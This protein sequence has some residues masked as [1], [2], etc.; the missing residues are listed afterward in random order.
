[1]DITRAA[2]DLIRGLDRAVLASAL[3]VSPPGSA[4]WP[5]ASLVLVAADHDLSPLLLISNL[6]EHTRA[7]AQDDRVS[8]L[9]DG[10]AGLAQPL[11]GPRL[12]VL[13]RAAP[14]TDARLIARYLGRHP[15]AALYASFADFQFYRMAIERAHLVG[16]FGKIYWIAAADLLSAPPPAALVEAEAEIVAHMNDD[17]ADALDLY[18]TRLLGQPG[19][20]WRMTGIDSEG[21]DLRREGLVRRVPFGHPVGTADEARKALVSLAFQARATK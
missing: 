20:G 8:L 6:A 13:G 18:A 10:T 15:D 5:Y 2:R 4:P 1:M 21:L 3:P 19:A 17:H 14:S 7:I 11:T 16:G 12:S 9:F